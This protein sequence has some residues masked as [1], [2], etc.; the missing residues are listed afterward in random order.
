MQELPAGMLSIIII[1]QDLSRQC[2]DS[3]QFWALQI[4]PATPQDTRCS[5]PPRQRYC[6]LFFL[7]KQ[8]YLKT[9][10]RKQPYPDCTEAFITGLI[11]KREMIKAPLLDNM[12]STAWRQTEANKRLQPL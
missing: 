8:P 9:I 12:R 11:S 7:M 6:H 4:S 2:Q 10:L 1:I 3:K 5:P